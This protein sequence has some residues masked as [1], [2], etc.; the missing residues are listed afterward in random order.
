MTA[1]L[2]A[3]PKMHECGACHRLF[4]ELGDVFSHDCPEA[5]AASTYRRMVTDVTIGSRE[6]SRTSTPTTGGQGGQGIERPTEKQTAFLR[7][8]LAERVGVEEI[9]ASLNAHREAGTLSKRV[10]SAAIESLQALAPRKIP[11]DVKPAGPG[12]TEK[13]TLLAIPAGRYFV[14]DTFVKVDRPSKGTYAGFIFVKRQSHPDD[15]GIRMAML[16]PKSARATVDEGY[17]HVLEA[18]LEDPSKAAVEYGHRTGSCC[19]CGRTLTDP[20]SIE[21]GIGP[22][23][24]SKFG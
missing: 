7:T 12:T 4:P 17:R 14:L 1:S 18:L 9:R 8:L 19:I 6:L 5:R 22:I 23:C 21:A 3:E 13:E 16:N 24:A 15:D 20:A 10:V 2:L 11:G